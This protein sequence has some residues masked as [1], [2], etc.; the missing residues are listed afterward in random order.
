MD[1]SES[2]NEKQKKE[3][4]YLD[5]ELLKKGLR[6]DVQLY[7][8]LKRCSDKKD[9][10]EWNEWRENHPDEDVLLEKANFSRF[11][12]KEAYLHTG[13]FGYPNKFKGKVHL[14]GANFEKADLEE[15]QLNFAHLEKA[16]FT[17][18]NLKKARFDRAYLLGAFFF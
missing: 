8:M 6:C 7:E 3:P 9:I 14:E 16:S 1:E 13:P 2:K 4:L 10:T 12:L 15:A 17:W 5:R 18:V 11:Y